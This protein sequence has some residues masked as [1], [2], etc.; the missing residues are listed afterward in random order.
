MKATASSDEED[1]DE[2]AEDPTADLRRENAKLKK[3]VRGLLEAHNKSTAENS[4][5]LNALEAE[6]REEVSEEMKG[7]RESFEREREAHLRRRQVKCG[8]GGRGELRVGGGRIKG[9][10]GE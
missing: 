4:V 7:L 10:S 1:E 2:E 9:C 5:K 6:I 3:A 8:G